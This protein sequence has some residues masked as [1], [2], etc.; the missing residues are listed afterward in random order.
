M[1]LEYLSVEPIV[2]VKWREL[3]LALCGAPAAAE[4]CWC[5]GRCTEQLSAWLGGQQ[6]IARHEMT[7]YF[8]DYV[9]SAIASPYPAMLLAFCSSLVTKGS[10]QLFNCSLCDMGAE[11]ELQDPANKKYILADAQLQQLTGET[12][13]AAFG[14]AKYLSKHLSPVA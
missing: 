10:V 3:C 7:R 1:H 11:N 12:R 8:W 2:R 14:F 5:A 6:T 4:C 9:K 13:F